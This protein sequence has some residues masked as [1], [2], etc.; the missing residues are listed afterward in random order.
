VSDEPHV[1]PLTHAL[2]PIWPP[3]FF[4]K[5]LLADIRELKKRPVYIE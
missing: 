4:I 1:L 3:D 5:L 2:P